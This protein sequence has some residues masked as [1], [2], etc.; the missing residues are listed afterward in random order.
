[1]SFFDALGPSKA[2]PK[3][4]E[5]FELIG[6]RFTCQRDDCWEA[7]HE[8]K[9]FEDALLLTWKCPAGHIS[10]ILDFEL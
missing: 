7:A 2:Q 6:G 5:Q 3:P 8:A 10:K 4:E 1:M 9:Y